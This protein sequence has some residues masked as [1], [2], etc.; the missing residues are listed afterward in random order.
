MTCW[1]NLH[2]SKFVCYHKER[3]AA[4]NQYG[5]STSVPEKSRSV[6]YIERRFWLH[7][8][9]EACIF[10]EK[11]KP[12]RRPPPRRFLRDMDMF[13]VRPQS[14]W[15]GTSSLL[16][17]ETDHMLVSSPQLASLKQYHGKAAKRIKRQ[18]KT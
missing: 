6:C 2:H 3:S 17:S 4:E 1:E 18:H 9:F 11:Q 10:D 12:D 15:T 14:F 13:A 7:V 8:F 16:L 5:Q